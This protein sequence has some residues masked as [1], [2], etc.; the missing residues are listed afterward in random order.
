MNEINAWDLFFKTGKVSDYLAYKNLRSLNEKEYGG[1][2]HNRRTD[3][4]NH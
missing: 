1:E 3:N 2:I 4:K